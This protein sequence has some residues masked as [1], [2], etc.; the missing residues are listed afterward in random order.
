MT[1][2]PHLAA[3]TNDIMRNRGWISTGEVWHVNQDALTLKYRKG[4]K[5]TA[6]MFSGLEM[7][8][9]RPEAV[10]GVAKLAADRAEMEMIG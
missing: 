2:L 6:I 9:I 1:D 4:S 7:L 10:A 3:V 5:S 8:Q